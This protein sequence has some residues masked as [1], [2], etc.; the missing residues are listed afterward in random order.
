MNLNDTVKLN[1]GVEMPRLGF[2]VFQVKPGVLTEQVVRKA[3]EVGYRS[4]DTAA[5]YGNEADVGKAVIA[6]GIPRREIFITTK[7]WNADQGYASTLKAF[8]ISRNKLQ[9]DYLDLYLINWPVKGRYADT[10][11]A[12]EKLYQDGMVRSI[13]LSNFHIHHIQDILSVCQVRPAVDQVELHPRLRQAELHQFCLENQIQ[14]EGWAPLMRGRAFTIPTIVEIAA[15]HRKTSAQVLIR[16]H[17]QHGIVAIPKSVT[18]HRIVENTQVFDFQ[19]S[20]EEMKRIDAL[21]QNQ[22]VGPDPDNF[23]F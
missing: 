12:M 1:N 18:P 16:W 20:E 6:S 10:W 23:N 22:R 21:N 15:K 14:I 4:I 3:L 7:V 9:T 5:I 2:G 13:G 17:L 8:D 19:L 11:R